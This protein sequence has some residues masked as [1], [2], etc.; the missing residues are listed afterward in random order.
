MSPTS[1]TTAWSSCLHDVIPP[2]TE[3]VPGAPTTGNRQSFYLYRTGKQKKRI[4]PSVLFSFF[5][6]KLHPWFLGG[7]APKM[8]AAGVA[9]S[10]AR[11]DSPAVCLSSPRRNPRAVETA[12]GKHSGGKINWFCAAKRSGEQAVIPS[13]E[14]HSPCCYLG[15]FRERRD[16]PLIDNI[17]E[18]TFTEGTAVLPF[19][20]LF[21]G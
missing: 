14:N 20:L 11:R 12:Q 5:C 15:S 6:V 3:K 19:L 1:S 13:A 17:P 18:K 16:K 7:G 21:R 10:G 4:A 2:V 8:A 9:S